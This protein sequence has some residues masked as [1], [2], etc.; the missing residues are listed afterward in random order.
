[1]L[2][3]EPIRKL[4]RSRGELIPEW[5]K[6]MNEFEKENAGFIDENKANELLERALDRV[7]RGEFIV[8]SLLCSHYIFGDLD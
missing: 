2:D 8:R 5:I 6:A 3:L 7:K 4:C 1:M